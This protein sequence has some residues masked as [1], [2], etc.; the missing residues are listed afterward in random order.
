MK[1]IATVSLAFLILGCVSKGEVKLL[2]KS[3]SGADNAQSTANKFLSDYEEGRQPD[4]MTIV[5][6]PLISGKKV[7]NS[8]L[9]PSVFNKPWTYS[10]QKEKR[11]IDIVENISSEMGVIIS[12]KDDVYNPDN[13]KTDTLDS[14]TASSAAVT[15]QNEVRTET[16]LERSDRIKLPAG[17]SYNGTLK[18]FFDYFSSVLNIEWVYL[19]DQKRVLLTRYVVKP[20]TVLLTNNEENEDT[21]EII[22]ESI[23][24]FSSRGGSVEVNPGTASVTV[25]D[26]RDVQSM[27]AAYLLEI[28]NSLSQQVNLKIVTYTIRLADSENSGVRLSGQ[29][30]KIS[31]GTSEGGLSIGGF[32]SSIAGAGS[33][34]ASILSGPFNG[35]QLLLQNIDEKSEITGEKTSLISTLNNQKATFEKKETIPIL[36]SF[37][38]ASISDGVVIPGSAQLTDKVVGYTMNLVPT[39]LADGNNMILSFELN[40]TEITGFEEVSAGGNGATLQSLRTADVS[41]KH[42]FKLVNG[43]SIAISGLKDDKTNFTESNFGGDGWFASLFSWIG[44][45]A[46]DMAENSYSVIVITPYISTGV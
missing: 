27:V 46:S 22:K 5:D 29:Y 15:V 18:G 43:Q 23:E 33:L 4:K 35:T 37:T 8:S 34:T 38:P 16:N 25:I 26:T 1:I 7:S 17:S 45:S 6:F 19:E 9:L 42:S 10:A 12:A 28:N 20:Y 32:G 30:S 2:D 41:Y 3:R 40:N 31:G 21:W 14:S 11:L 24:S 39:I 44:S 13:G 36:S